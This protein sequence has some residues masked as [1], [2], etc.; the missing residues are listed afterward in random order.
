MFRNQY[1]IVS[2]K[3]ESNFQEIIPTYFNG[4]H[5]YVKAYTNTTIA[6]H[7]ETEIC[8]IGYVIDPQNPEYSN[9]Q[10]ITNLAQQCQT[11]KLFFQKIQTLSGRYVL[12]YKNQLSF[13]V[14][15]DACNLRQIYFNVSNNR[16]VITSSVQMFLTY[17]NYEP[18]ISQLKKDFINDPIYKQ[19]ESA[20]YGNKSIF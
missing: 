13:L 14:T 17:Y 19:K 8:L 18:E 2:D 3:V 5:L 10:I 20:W 9:E 1:L 11:E 16:T 4:L 12:I 15:G 7:S 6:K